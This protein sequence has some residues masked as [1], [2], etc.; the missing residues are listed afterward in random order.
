MKTNIR[1]YQYENYSH[2]DIEN[3]GFT[4]LKKVYEYHH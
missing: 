2:D 3:F 4:D 1:I